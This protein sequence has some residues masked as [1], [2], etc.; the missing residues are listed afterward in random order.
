MA[1]VLPRDRHKIKPCKTYIRP[2][3]LA[4]LARRRRSVKACAPVP[5]SAF[6]LRTENLLAH[7]SP[8]PISF[9]FLFYLCYHSVPRPIG[10]ANYR[11][12]EE[13]EEE[14]FSKVKS[15]VN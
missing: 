3:L 1:R 4:F 11:R 14:C 8:R 9:S 12:Q 10:V 7:L 6:V 5:P 13:D 2:T 15:P